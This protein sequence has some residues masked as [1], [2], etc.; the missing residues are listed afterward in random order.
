MI[1][2]KQVR[3]ILRNMGKWESLAKT[4]HDL[5]VAKV[6]VPQNFG[7]DLYEVTAGGM[8]DMI[9]DT[10]K[11]RVGVSFTLKLEESLRRTNGENPYAELNLDEIKLT[12]WKDSNPFPAQ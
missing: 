5:N 11:R 1:S 10:P 9:D 8:Q 6:T 4:A 3:D 12:E 2:P 7:W